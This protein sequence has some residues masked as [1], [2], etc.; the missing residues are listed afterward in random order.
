MQQQILI[1][2][3]EGAAASGRVV[4]SAKNTASHEGIIRCHQERWYSM[5]SLNYTV[6][7][8]NSGSLVNYKKH[9]CE[10]DL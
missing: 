7:F 3:F 1:L 9:I 8:I 5:S 6:A 4:S 10:K 2:I